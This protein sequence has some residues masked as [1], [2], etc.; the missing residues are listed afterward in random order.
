MTFLWKH[1]RTIFD[2]SEIDKNTTH[3]YF[4]DLYNKKIKKNV[5]P[6]NITFI[7]FG[8]SFNQ[9]IDNLPNS[10]QSLHFG[11]TFSQNVRKWPDSLT[12]LVLGERFNCEINNL[13]CS[14]EELTIHNPNYK[15]KLN[16]L[17]VCLRKFTLTPVAHIYENEFVHKLPL[18]CDFESMSNK[19]SA[20]EHNKIS[21]NKILYKF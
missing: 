8:Y 20:H 13:P 9:N 12:T 5:L 1:N 10:V 16:N 21:R 17:P 4:G 2:K 18:N 14:M 7:Y 19:N 6:D 15:K 3:L 11:Y